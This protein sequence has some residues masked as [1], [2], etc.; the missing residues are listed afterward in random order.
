MIVVHLQDGHN[1]GVIMRHLNVH[2]KSV[3]HC[4]ASLHVIAYHV[5]NLST[6]AHSVMLGIESLA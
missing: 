4:V 3:R 1:I 6:H 5:S 2:L